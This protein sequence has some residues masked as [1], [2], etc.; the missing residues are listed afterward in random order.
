MGK[1]GIKENLILLTG[2]YKN[3]HIESFGVPAD[4]QVKVRFFG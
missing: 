3:I 2:M 1:S 4:R